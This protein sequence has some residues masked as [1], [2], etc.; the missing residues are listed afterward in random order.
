M[1]VCHGTPESFSLVDTG[2]I[3]FGVSPTDMVFPGNMS[4]CIRQ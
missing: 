3:S 2:P 4:V 1:L